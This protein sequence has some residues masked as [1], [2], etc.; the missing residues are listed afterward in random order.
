MYADKKKLIC[1]VVLAV[2][3]VFGSIS[4]VNAQSQPEP[5]F[6]LA[7]NEIDIIKLVQI[8][9]NA[10]GKIIVVD[11]SVKG[12]VKIMTNNSALN[13]DELFDLFRAALELSNFSV[14]EAGNVVKVIPIKEARTSAIPD[15]G[16]NNGMSEVVTDVIPA[17][18]ISAAKL[19]AALRPL[20][21]ANYNI[22]HHDGSNSIIITD[23]RAN[24]ERI[25]RVIKKI[26]TAAIPTT[27]VVQLRYAEAEPL[28]Q[29]LTKLDGQD[30]AAAGLSN[31]LQIVADSRNNAILL[32]G[33]DLQRDRVKKL[34]KML[35]RPAAQTGNVRVVYLEYADAVKVAAT[36]TKVVQNISKLG[37]GGQA[38]AAA[39]NAAT[40]EADE[41]TNALL[42]TAEG[43]TLNSLLAVV[44][45]LDIRRAQVLVE[46]IIVE[47]NIS[48]N[49]ELGTEWLFSNENEGVFG[50]GPQGGGAAPT[51]AGAIADESLTSLATGLS[52]FTGNTFG[53]AGIG[54]SEN[55]L[56]LIRA[57]DSSSNANILS[58]PTLLTM[59]N[60]EAEISVGQEVP[61]QT[62]S[63]SSVG[64]SGNVSSPFTTFQR[65]SIGILLKIT[66]QI[67]EGDKILLDIEQEVS[68]I[69]SELQSGGL[70]T[71]ESKITTQVMAQDGEIVVLGGLM[72]EEAEQGS[73]KVPVLGSI[74]I[75]GYLFKY[76]TTTISK[77]NLMVFLRA[78][79]IRDDDVMSAATAE[80]YQKMRDKQIEVRDNGLPL[81]ADEHLPLLPDATFRELIGADSA[82]ST[83]EEEVVSE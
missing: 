49:E 18:N 77:K 19:L 40:V 11:P 29:T 36:L 15:L 34:I 2:L 80:K 8:V 68:G 59:D 30:K 70:I 55:F 6:T 69:D 53:I 79:I 37:P 39:P 65:E 24:I 57:L 51:L 38:N 46:A 1:S 63:F 26:D 71:R 74:P 21:S 48:E 32:A 25:R 5:T 75:L 28:V 83:D 73:S 76:Q 22:N 47:L 14:V 20:V 62:G 3:T 66:P 52:G 4:T 33:E 31:K 72:E 13:K 10:T 58:T 56:A 42:I 16:A 61:F 12:K 67:N 60:K 64:N 81:M 82:E 44:E 78:E 54:G 27:E 43:D 45:R 41:D 50:A 35:D 17:Q 9:A 7:S 23:T